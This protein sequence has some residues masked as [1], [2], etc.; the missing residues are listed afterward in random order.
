MEYRSVKI[1]IA[2]EYER[3]SCEYRQILLH[4]NRHVAIAR[5]N[6]E[7]FKPQVRAALT[8]LLIPKPD[9][10]IRI[11]SAS[12]AGAEMERLYTKLL[13]PVYQKMLAALRAAQGAID[14]PEAYAKVH[15]KCDN[16]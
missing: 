2:S 15:R 4:E 5:R 9:Q 6:L 8:S 16:W 10:P 14:T 7:R 1:Y 11:A 12:S 13:E 3:G